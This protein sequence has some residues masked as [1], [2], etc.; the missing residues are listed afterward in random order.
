MATL[1]SLR[2]A[3][4][5]NLSGYLASHQMMIAKKTCRAY[6][7]TRGGVYQ[8][9]SIAVLSSGNNARVFVTCTV[10]EV[11]DDPNEKSFLEGPLV[12]YTGGS[13]SEMGLGLGDFLDP[14]VSTEMACQ[15]FFEMLP[16]YLCRFADPLFNAIQTRRDFWSALDED[17]KRAL[18]GKGLKHRILTGA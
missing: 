3:M 6:R 17:S 12:M 18:E 13:L 14:D 8:I 1:A 11:F 15:A 5:K 10:P 9:I 16:E 2:R 7:V 4:E